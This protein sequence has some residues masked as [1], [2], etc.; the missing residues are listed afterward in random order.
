MG[1]SVMCVRPSNCNQR[2]A[3]LRRC[4]CFHIF[5]Q[6]LGF[7]WVWIQLYFVEGLLQNISPDKLA[8]YLFEYIY[9]L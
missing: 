9:F 7:R 5:H 6:N 2:G 1:L 4:S 3:E 8:A